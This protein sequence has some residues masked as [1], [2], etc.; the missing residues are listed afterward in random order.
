MTVISAALSAKKKGDSVIRRDLGVVLTDSERAD[1]DGLVLAVAAVLGVLLKRLVRLQQRVRPRV[2]DEHLGLALLPAREELGVCDTELRTE[3]REHVEVHVVQIDLLRLEA[4][5]IAPRSVH[6]ATLDPRAA[7][8][9]DVLDQQAE[10]AQGG[11][12]VLGALDAHNRSRRLRHLGS[13]R[14]DSRPR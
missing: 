6:L 11:R 12:A 14:P 9:L 7:V 1:P 2:R 10:L 4:V 13:E 8:L 3:P 5:H